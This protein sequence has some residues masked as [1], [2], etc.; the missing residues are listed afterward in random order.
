V[1]R[2]V[3]RARTVAVGEA[4]GEGSL[5]SRH[6]REFVGIV[7]ASAAVLAVYANALFMQKGPHPAPIFAARPPAAASTV[8]VQPRV[9]MPS[10]R[11][12]TVVTAITPSTAP[13]PLNRVQLI[14]EI[15]RALSRRGF[16]D[17]TADGIWG[18][19]TDA[20]VRDFVR[21]TGLNINPEA[22]EEVLRA[23]SAAN[24]TAR[25][26]ALPA[27]PRNDPIAALIA[28]SQRVLAIQHA[29]AD[30]GYGQITPSGT[31]DPA[32]RTAIEK[33]ERDRNLPV[34]GDISERFVRE[35]AAMTGRPL[36]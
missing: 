15:Q 20:G 32:T 2:G 3:N 14:V 27:T 4:S 25:T 12:V 30:F 34:T 17:G 31:Y 10:A 22:S 24:V 8:A 26:A 5:I 16:Y 23:L 29:L 11:P 18:A 28:P 9:A 6:P 35:L 33:F 7:L 13:A 21:A 36:E 1:P 19:K